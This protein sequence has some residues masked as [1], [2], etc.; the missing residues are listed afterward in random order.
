M[1]RLPG[2]QDLA[3]S[4][5][6]KIV[7]TDRRIWISTNDWS[8]AYSIAIFLE[9]ISVVERKHT[10]TPLYL[11]LGMLALLGSVYQFI[12][13]SGEDKLYLAFF[14]GAVVFLL[15]WMTSR[16]HLICVTSHSGISLNYE[17]AQM[18]KKE[19]EKFMDDVQ[20]AKYD[21]VNKLHSIQ[22]E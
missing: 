10:S 5:S 13:T 11:I 22:P 3:K 21:L 9:D 12:T 16:R 8:N 14:V 18:T 15:V 7:L 4:I 20:Q 6:D 2:E 17:V 1:K 19:I